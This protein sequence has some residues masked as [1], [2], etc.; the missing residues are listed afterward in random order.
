VNDSLLFPA[1]WVRIVVGLISVSVC[2]FVCPTSQKPNARTSPN[3]SVHVT[4]GRGLV[5]LWWYCD[6]L[7][8]R[9]CT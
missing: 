3:F 4:C 5:V 9:F 6:I 8:F 2:L 7:C 1:E